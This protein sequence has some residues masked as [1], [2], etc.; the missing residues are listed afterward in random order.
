M[1]KVRVLCTLERKWVEDSKKLHLFNYW[2]YRYFT[3][4]FE[5]YLIKECV[6]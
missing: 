3:N 2:F 4:E 5:L 1:S 6:K